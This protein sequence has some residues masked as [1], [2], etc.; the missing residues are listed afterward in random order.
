METTEQDVMR[1]GG[2]TQEEEH[3]SDGQAEQTEQQVKHVQAESDSM[4]DRFQ[5]AAVAAVEH[6]HS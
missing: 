2:S 3:R 1:A 4:A 6:Q 5:K